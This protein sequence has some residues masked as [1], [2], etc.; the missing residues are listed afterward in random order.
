MRLPAPIFSIA[1]LL[2]PKI[3][4]SQIQDNFSDGNLSQNPIWQGNADHFIINPA[5][6]LQLNAPAAGNSFLFTEGN[7]PDSAVWEIY[8]RLEFPPSA[9]NRLRIYLQTDGADMQIT[10][11]YFLEIGEN[12][13]ADALRFFRQDA[14]G[15]VL[16]GTGTAATLANEPSLARLQILRKKGGQWKIGADFT[17]ND[18]FLP[19]IE[20]TDA[21]WPGGENHFFGFDCLFSA[22]RKDKFFFD[23]L[24]ILPDLPDQT[25]PKLIA[26]EAI[27]SQEL[28]IFFDEKLDPVDASDP[29]HFSVDKNIGQPVFAGPL[30]GN[31]KA[32]RLVF[33][34]NF[35]DGQSHVLTTVGLTDE[36]GNPS[37]S[38]TASFVFLKIGKPA[39]FD[40]LLNEIMADP[41]PSVGLPEFEWVEIINRSAKNIDLQQVTLS[42]GGSPVNLPKYILRPDSL[43]LLIAKS[44]EAHFLGIKNRVALLNFPAISNLA[45]ELTLAD[46]NGE[47][48]DFVAF[49]PAFY[50]NDSKKDG[51]WSLE[52]INP[53]RPC[54]AGFENWAASKTV[55]GG[56]PGLR[57]SNFSDEKDGA[58][59]KLI[60]VFPKSPVLLRAQVSE[61]L[62][63]AATAD[64]SNFKIEP[65]LPILSVKPEWS[66]S[67]FLIISLGQ[68]I[69]PSQIYQLK[70]AENAVDCSGNLFTQ[71]NE[72]PFALAELP[73]AN[74]LIIN[75]LLF[76][77]L[78]GGVDFL[79]IF[80]RS[81]KV[82]NL[83]GLFIG[84]ISADGAEV[85]KCT[86]ERFIFPGE[87]AVLTPDTADVRANFFVKN[88][89][90][91]HKNALP[92]FDDDAGNVQ[93]YR[94]TGPTEV[95]V[96]DDF[97]YSKQLHHAL[98][99]DEEKENRALE[100]V[101]MVIATNDPTNWQTAAA[102]AAQGNS[103]PG[104]GTPTAQNSQSQS[105]QFIDNEWVTLSNERV[106]PDGD[107]YEDFLLVDLNLPSAGF[108]GHIDIFSED[109]RKVKTISGEQL[110]GINPRFRWDGELDSGGPAPIG[111]YILQAGFLHPDGRSLRKNLTVAVLKKW[112]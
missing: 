13:A 96:L 40:I 75:E 18:N 27:D 12:G 32:V 6:E 38:E 107:G 33:S 59:A 99:N 91:L 37:I 11:G 74:D 15:A 28:H 95:L 2:L 85:K 19:Q 111:I 61:G 39:L 70:I 58:G 105:A 106:S 8:F 66:G 76:N 26:A 44:S 69:Q 63:E 89:A 94:E 112:N 42:A 88:P 72:K 34:K 49:D 3:A 48:L 60:S 24:K 104:H 43:V 57:N 31:A 108:S 93:I 87:F 35:L 79:E 46:Q 81:K 17:G 68:P 77:P 82:I 45:D 56:S 78:S 41:S 5:A 20:A 100:R 47:T 4:F 97:D 98:L 10:N 29:A 16:L 62:A 90:W 101:N 86:V 50:K 14:G 110:S 65:A 22:S 102:P 52:R 73:E 53:N 92:G 25:P 64:F 30:A 54:A 36:I 109:G 7:I 9:T 84:N 21:K 1:L 71:I 103:A 55:P 23:D 51:G 80:N 67:P 83:A